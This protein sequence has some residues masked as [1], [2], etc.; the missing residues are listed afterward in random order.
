[1]SGEAGQWIVLRTGGTQTLPLVRSLK[2]A[3]FDVW[4][5]TKIV[6]RPDTK[7]RR[8]YVLGQRRQYVEKSEAIL[9]GFAFA[10]ARHFDDMAEI[11]ICPLRQ[12]P[13]FSLWQHAGRAPILP[14]RA[15][16]GL[17]EAERD[18]L[19][20]AEEMRGVRS[21]D[22]ARRKRAEQ[23]RTERERVKMLRRER[24][25]F[26]AGQTVAVTDMPSMEG[27]VGRIVKSNGKAATVN[28][29]GA[30]EFEI[31]AWRIVPTALLDSAA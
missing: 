9:P 8:R 1:M 10:A 13:G 24:R 23:M 17:R 26:A 15:L 6:F 21:R 27:M 12:H 22:E 14:E 31:E 18:A 25:D 11:A 20:L 3:G 28:F 4:A 7:Q 19:A 30:I 5:P 2:S 16:S 29:G